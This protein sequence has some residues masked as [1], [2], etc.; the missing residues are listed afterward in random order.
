MVPAIVAQRAISTPDMINFDAMFD[1]MAFKD[2]EAGQL[3]YRWSGK[4]GNQTL[5]AAMC[6]EAKSL[7][8]MQ[9]DALLPKPVADK[10]RALVQSKWNNLAMQVANYGHVVSVTFDQPSVEYL[11]GY[12]G[13]KRIALNARMHSQRECE[14]EARERLATVQ[15]LE[16]AEK[17]LDVMEGHS[18]NRGKLEMQDIGRSAKV[19]TQAE[20]NE[21]KLR[22]TALRIHRDSLTPKRQL[23]AERRKEAAAKAAATK[24]AKAAE[25]EAASKA[26]GNVVLA[27]AKAAK[28]EKQKEAILAKYSAFELT[29]NE[30]EEKLL[31]LGVKAELPNRSEHLT[32]KTKGKNRKKSTRKSGQKNKA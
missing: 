6:K 26:A 13:V 29:A 32:S 24:A 9:A 21:Q 23:D 18:L 28:R 27:A 17:R 19:Y 10:I 31:A 30:A 22:I 4:R 14:S 16:A 7:L 12:K 20:I 25:K 15:L 1:S 5:F 2:R 11:D 3:N 8:G